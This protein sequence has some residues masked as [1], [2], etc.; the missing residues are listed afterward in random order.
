MNESN[1]SVILCCSFL[2]SIKRTI[3]LIT[4]SKNIVKGFRIEDIDETRNYLIEKN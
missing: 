4:I 3:K 1:V 2:L